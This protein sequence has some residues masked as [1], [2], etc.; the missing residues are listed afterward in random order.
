MVK[1]LHDKMP[2]RL[3]NNVPS[4]TIEGSMVDVVNGIHNSVTTVIY[5]IALEENVE[6]TDS[7]YMKISWILFG[8]VCN[9]ISRVFDKDFCIQKMKP[10]K[11]TEIEKNISE[12]PNGINN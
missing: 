7:L 11:K 4:L 5:I 2:V 8:I 1:L 10:Q 9:S 12:I 3:N 6:I